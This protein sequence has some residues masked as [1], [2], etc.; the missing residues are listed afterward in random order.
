MDADSLY[1]ALSEEK[2]HEITRPELLTLWFKM[3]P[4]DFNVNC[5]ANSNIS[6]FQRECCNKH[7]AF[8]KLHLVFLM[9]NF[10]VLRCLHS[11]RNFTAA[12]MSS[13]IQ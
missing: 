5:A 4:A 3:R 11:S 13:Q 12:T 10:G 6:F 9:S 2:L 8:D 1:M 7:A